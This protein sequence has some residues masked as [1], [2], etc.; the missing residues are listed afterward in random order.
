MRADIAQLQHDL[1]TTTIYVT[2]DQVEA[3]TMGDRVA[4]MS[5]GELQQV[6]TPQNLYDRPANLFVAGFIGTPPMNLLEADVVKDNGGVALALGPQ[7]LP[8]SDTTLA[9]YPGI[10]GHSGRAV[11]GIR[12]DDLSLARSR[13]D[14][15]SLAARVQLVEA[16]GSQSMGYFRIDAH[17]IRSGAGG[18]ED[19]VEEEGA[20]EGVT[21]ARPNL[22]AAFTPREAL[23][24]RLD[25]DVPIAV[26]VS[27]VHLFD[28]ETGAPLR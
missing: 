19:A 6:D 16:L 12:S 11:L 3:M 17:A 1:G 13:P 10:R 9:R 21:A 2:H 26:D 28:A 27:Q 22:V 14:L 5:Q 25:D 23:E 15:P 8:L 20:G 18:V 7:R 24:L 4:V